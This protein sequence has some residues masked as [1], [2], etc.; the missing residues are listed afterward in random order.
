MRQIRIGLPTFSQNRLVT[1]Q[2]DEQVAQNVFHFN[3]REKN[4][5]T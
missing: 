4:A 5:I 3:E 1:L 2:N